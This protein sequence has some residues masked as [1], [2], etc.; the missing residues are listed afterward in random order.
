MK[1]DAP[2]S[3]GLFGG[4][5]SFG[6]SPASSGLGNKLFGSS[7]DKEEEEE[8]IA[9]EEADDETPPPSDSEDSDSDNDSDDSESE[10]EKSVLAAP[11]STPASSSPWSAAPSY[12][13]LYLS[14][15]LEYIP[16]PP[17][18][19]APPGVEDNSAVG[20]GKSRKAEE[21]AEKEDQAAWNNAMEGYE[22]SLEVDKVFERFA[23]RVGY[24]G[25]Q[26]IR[27]D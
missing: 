21:R 11:A 23:R 3:G 2:L 17:K 9:S 15:A 4:T 16:P 12:K 8:G 6:A 25:Q 1:S 22:D 26:C 7:Q 20:G 24:E 18:V 5:P 10:S 19:K 27:Y 13:P 14:T